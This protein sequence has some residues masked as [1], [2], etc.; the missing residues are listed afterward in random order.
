MAGVWP[1]LDLSDL[2]TRVRTY[3]NEVTASFFTQAEIYRWLSVAAKDIAQKSLC[4]RRIIDA[5]TANA[6]RTV[7]TNVYKVLY[8][9]Y[10]PASGRPVMLAKI[11]PIK[12]GGV[13]LNGTA[14][15]Y[16]YELGNT[17]GIEPVPDAI[18]NL[19]LY[20][21]DMPHICYATQYP[22]YNWTGTPTWTGSGTGTFSNA[23]TQNA[24]T[25][26][27]GQV[28]IDTASSI[29]AATT[30][31]VFWFTLSGVSNCGMTISAGTTASQI[32]NTNGHHCCKLTSAGN[33]NCVITTTMTGAT[34]GI[35][36]TNLYIAKEADFAAATDQTELTAAWQHLMVIYAT[37]KALRKDR[38]AAAAVML[39]DVYAKEVEYL[40]QNIVDIIPDGKDAIKYQ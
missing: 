6:T 13:P 16:W 32:F 24:Y 36:I 27:T 34:G 7:T 10:L 28:G 3:I 5:V 23:A 38:K 22:V 30:P 26:T 29:L 35:T 25:G 8:V 1:N 19:R 17:I 40:K 39:E 18:Y 15:Q 31:H 12:V 37:A 4:V 9:E 2:E 33:T 20:A 14:P 21:A 11:D